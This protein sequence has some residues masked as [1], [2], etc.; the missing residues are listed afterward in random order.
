MTAPIH[1]FEAAG[2]GLAPFRFVGMEHKTF[3]ACPGAPI[4]VGGSCD[5]CS[6]GISY[7]CWIES[8]D[9]RRFKVGSDCVAKVDPALAASVKRADADAR[10]EAR[11]QA[12]KDL[13]VEEARIKRESRVARANA[14][15]DNVPGLRAAFDAGASAPEAFAKQRAILA[16][17]HA[18]TIFYG[19]LT[20][21]QVAFARKLG[22]EILNPRPAE[23][24]VPAPTGQ[25]RVKVDGTVVA[26]REVPDRFSYRPD[27][28]AFKMIV[29]V[30]AEGGCWLCWS[31][32]PG[33]IRTVQR[34]DRVRFV[35]TLEPGNDPHFAF[36]KRP[37]KAELVAEVGR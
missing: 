4:Q 19:S 14:Y 25:G 34:G 31:S 10:L 17:L 11:R 22:D 23:V 13:A 7:F 32:I 37:S 8:A 9:G 36:A 35:A 6:T 29:R 20:E 15:I 1:P 26:I 28:V 21:K 5:Y 24:H 12:A 3:Q 2:L 27:A 18:K 16:D 30:E 33:A